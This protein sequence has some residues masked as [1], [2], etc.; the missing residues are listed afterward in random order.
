MEVITTHINADFDTLASMVAAKKL[1]PEAVVVFPG[2]VEKAVRDFLGTYPIADFEHVKLGRINL[3][4]VE[5]L[6]L[7]DTR[8]R[9]RIGPFADI[10]ERKGLDI[11]IYDH[12][13]PSDDDIT[14]SIEI[15]D[16]YGSTTTIMIDLLKEKGIT[17]TVEE[18]T[19][20]MLG[21]YEDTGFL[22]FVS[23]TPEDYRASA[24]LLSEGADLKIVSDMIRREMTVDEVALLN[25]MNSSATI[26]RIHGQVIVIARASSDEY[27]EDAAILVHKMMDMNSIDVLF[28]L[29]RMGSK[30]Y[31]IAR[32][33]VKE[34][35]AGEV[36][37]ALGGGG[38][39]DA[40]SAVI[41]DLTLIDAKDRLLKILEEKV[42]EIRSAGDI[43]SSP[44][45]S[46]DPSRTLKQTKE[47]MAKFNINVLPVLKE[48]EL[49]G[50][51]SRQDVG[52]A[53]YHGLEEHLVREFMTPDYSTVDVEEPLSRIQEII[54]E[55]N[56]RFLPVMR[57]CKLAGC[58]TRTDI[59][60]VLHYDTKR[61]KE[62]IERAVHRKSLKGAIKAKLPGWLRD[63]LEKAGSKADE[64]GLNAYLVGGFV[65]DLILGRKN[66]DVDIVIEGDGIAYAEGLAG[67]FDGRVKSHRAFGTAV[68][69]MP[70]GFKIDVASA[71]MEFYEPAA[72][73]PKVE[74]GPIK[75]DLYRRDFTINSMAVRLNSR[76]FGELIDY[77]GGLMGIKEKAIRVLHASSFIED[78]TR[79][80]RAVRLEQRLGFQ[81]GKQTLTF[82]KN[83]ASLDFFDRVPPPRIFNELKIILEEKAPLRALKRMDE[84]DIMRFIHRKFRIDPDV[85]NLFHELQKVMDWYELLFSKEGYDR[86]VL[87][88]AALQREL[89]L[90]EVVEMAGNIGLAAKYRDKLTEIKRVCEEK[91]ASLGED[92][93]DNCTLYHLLVPLKVETLLFMMA[94]AKNV[95]VKE[96]ISRFIREL[97]GI[98]VETTGEDLKCL[99]FIQ[100]PVYGEIKKRLLDERL[101]GM[102]KSREDEI[103]YIKRYWLKDAKSGEDS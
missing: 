94:R 20:M 47:I 91:T 62:L 23:T 29:M 21:I 101:K 83:A 72:A 52:R 69:V 11:H 48:G 99:G 17:I 43:M 7:V 26:H 56:Q 53:I 24:Y 44:V 73:L 77:Y 55:E 28:A 92:D 89:N 33:R 45:K 71:R 93:L 97:K 65:R 103:S 68:V 50:L 14:G 67:I 37:E 49:I 95:R 10:I 36:A 59:L 8:Q 13:P 102:V 51:I 12:H 42:K 76:G 34:V 27:I 22:S 85:E 90:D 54:I 96:R 81:I 1:Y 78:P 87:L 64:M 30:I 35:D 5:R 60:R 88:F 75:M 41:R 79:A 86:W 2:G 82:M 25:D 39:P 9:G 66:L 46:I 32:S 74:A 6:I 84:L 31:L 4:E 19:V 16:R 57:E 80:F 98:T 18:A 70:D 63:I 40:A 15:T 38:H 3:D 58:I 100:G 61:G